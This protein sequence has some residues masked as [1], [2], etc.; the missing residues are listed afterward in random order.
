M[1]H[2]E[3]DAEAPAI[4]IH[5]LGAVSISDKSMFRYQ[6]Y[7]LGLPM[8]R[9]SDKTFAVSSD[10]IVY[11]LGWIRSFLNFYHD[12]SCSA[13]TPSLNVGPPSAAFQSTAGIS[14]I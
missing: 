12:V 6:E 9:N 14:T 5:A 1:I 10:V 7:V 2:D 4:A 13:C 11:P 8:I 3:D